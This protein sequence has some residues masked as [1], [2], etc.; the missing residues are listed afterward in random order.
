[1][2]IIPSLLRLWR[3]LGARL[4]QGFVLLI[5][6]ML[7]SAVAEVA[8]L[9]AVLPFLAVLADP[10]RLMQWP[11]V[12]AWSGR[13]GIEGADGLVMPLTLLF[14]TTVLIAAAIRM[15]LLWA[16][17]RFTLASGIRLSTLTFARAM[18]QP[19]EAHVDRSTRSVITALSVKVNSVVFAV[20]M[21]FLQLASSS[22]VLVL[23]I[24]GLL[25][26][27]PLV[28]ALAGGVLGGAYL[29]VTLATRKRM[30]LNSM[31]ISHFQDALVGRVQDGLGGIRDAILDSSQRVYID[32]YRDADVPLRQ[33][34]C[35]NTFIAQSPRIGMEALGMVM[36]AALAL[37]IARG[38]GGIAAAIPVLGAL[39]LGAQRLLPA[40]QQAYSAWQ[41][42]VGHQAVLDD[43]LYLL[44]QPVGK[45]LLAA[46]PAPMQWRDEIRFNDVTFSYSGS[47][48]PVLRDVSFVIGKGARVGI[49][50]ATGSGKTTAVDLLMG[51]LRPVTG[52][53]TVDGIELDGLSLRAWQRTV[54]HVP[55][56]IYLADASVASNI[57]LGVEEHA[58]DRA[59][60]EDAALQAEL[61]DYLAAQPSGLD[62]G[63]GERGVRLSGGQRQRIGIARALY[64]RASVLI[65]DEATS[66]LD[67]ATERSV[68]HTISKLDSNLTII[69]IAHRLSTVRD[70]DVIYEFNAGRLVAAGSY[71]S[72][73]ESSSTFRSMAE[74]THA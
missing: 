17:T 40:L 42:V 68:M 3:H 46:A 12:Q 13:L 20:V 52:T 53:I 61:G 26:I 59:L 74:A 18:L 65:L 25:L 1:M 60:A 33:A 4:R 71:E 32:A 69:M 22:L 10:S 55:Q 24:V 39:A 50:G 29:A 15:W 58:F 16:T 70:C 54:A 56:A 38:G 72:L 14:V 7:L 34:Q 30:Q 6:L 51:L 21:Q 64:K 31:S 19:Y 2:A 27:D 41:S 9:G 43:V 28:A 35:N 45:E 49:V 47:A 37:V 62:S 23:V 11:W 73:L 5:L 48:A 67:N 36:I 44:D 63:V 66:A 8:T 57:A